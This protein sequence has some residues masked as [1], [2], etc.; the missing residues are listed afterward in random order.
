MTRCYLFLFFVLLALAQQVSARNL[1]ETS[2]SSG[3]DR[4]AAPAEPE[5]TEDCDEEDMPRRAGE[6]PC[7]RRPVKD[8]ASTS[9]PDADDE[10]P[11]NEWGFD[12]ASWLPLSTLMM[13]DPV[14]GIRVL[15]RGFSASVYICIVGSVLL[16]CYM[17]SKRNAR[18]RERRG[19]GAGAGTASAARDR[20]LGRANAEA[21]RE[22]D[23]LRAEIERLRR[24]KERVD[25]ERRK[26]L[27]SGLS[28]TES[29]FDD[30]PIKKTKSK[31]A[32]GDN[33]T[34]K[35]VQNDAASAAAGGA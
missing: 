4:A 2:S 34:K 22:L 16:C 35:V 7:K 6:V 9:D 15:S 33:K 30:V 23:Q 1:D 26:R 24:A 12:T 32:A 14:T 10:K 27:A 25:K 19:A 5:K 29:V 13:E 31:K 28:T 8:N 18:K 17:R 3:N 11:D 21:S 20:E